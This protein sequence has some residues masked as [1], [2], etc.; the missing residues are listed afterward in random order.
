[1]KE[2]NYCKCYICWF[3]DFRR[4]EEVENVEEIRHSTMGLIGRIKTLED[5]EESSHYVTP[6][7]YIITGVQGEKYACKPDIFEESYEIYKE[8]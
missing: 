3:F 1:M 8:E 4:V 2:I 7:D 6:G 5:T